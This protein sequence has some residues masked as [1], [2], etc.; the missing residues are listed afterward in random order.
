[1]TDVWELAAYV[2]AHPDN[3]GQRWRLAKKLYTSWEYRLALEHLLVLKNES[4]PRENVMRYL[5]ATYYR[6]NRLDDSIETLEEALK[7]WPDNAGLL[8]Q[9]ARTQGEADYNE[10]ALKSWQALHELVPDHAFAQQAIARYRKIVEN[11]AKEKADS[12]QPVKVS[13]AGG[14]ENGNGVATTPPKEV[15]CPKCGQKNSAEFKRC[16]KCNAELT[17]SE[18]FLDGVIKRPERQEPARLPQPMVTGIIIAGLLALSVYLTLQ[19]I[20]HVEAIQPGGAPPASVPD[21][22]DLTLL[23]TRVGLGVVL[24]VGWPVAFR[25]AAYLTNV[26]N[27]IYNE[28]LYRSGALCALVAYALLWTPWQWMIAAV[29]VPVILSAVFAFAFFKV[30]LQQAAKVWVFQMAFVA[31][32][33]VTLIVSRH[34]PGLLLEAPQIVAFAREAGKIAPHEGVMTAPGELRVQ[35]QSSGSLWLNR[36]ANSMRLTLNAAEDRRMFLDT[37]EDG[38]TLSFEQL[39]GSEHIEDRAGIKVGVPYRFDVRSDE[40]VQVRYT[41]RSLLPFTVEQTAVP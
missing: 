21:F 41:V 13:E 10:D 38:K 5:A 26:E 11:E 29:I 18:D 9:L 39:N 32:L 35:W 22:M 16:W 6:L 36:Q 40:P 34:G 15:A 2:E 30:Y 31:L 14:S 17:H 27:R 12:L 23:W 28:T 8:E 19:G 20:A 25:L 4:E 24:L 37:L 3:Y 33:A 1:M 7:V